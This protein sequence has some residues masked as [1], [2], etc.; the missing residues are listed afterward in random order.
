MNRFLLKFLMIVSIIS[1]G[2]FSVCAIEVDTEELNSAQNANIVFKNFEGRHSKIE[3]VF[4]I[5]MIGI[6]LANMQ[7]KDNIEFRYW[8]KYSVI[9]AVDDDTE[10]K[11][12]DGVIFSINKDAQV[13]HINN[14]RLIITGYLERKFGYSREDAVTLSKFVIYYNA[15]HRGDMD[16]FNNKF[17]T[18]V[19][20]HLTA[21]DA[22][23]STDYDQ[24]AGK[25]K[26]VIPLTQ[27]AGKGKIGSL[28]TSTLGGK[29]VVDSM[30]NDDDK[31]V[32]DRKEL[33]NIKKKQ[34]DETNKDIKKEK[35]AVNKEKEKTAKK[36]EKVAQKEK[37]IKEKK[38]SIAEK[39]KQLQEEKDNLDSIEDEDERREKEKELNKQEQELDKEKEKVEKDEEK[40][41]SERSEVEEEKA[42]NEKT[43]EIL[44]KKQEKVKEQEEEVK[45]EEKDVA[46]DERNNKIENAP[47]DIKEELK[48][49]SEALDKREEELDKRED[50][51]KKNKPDNKTF[52]AKLFYL[53]IKE[54]MEGGHYNNELYVIDMETK[55]VAPNPAVTNVCG[56]KYVVMNE[57]IIL[58]GFEGK[59]SSDHFLMVLD[60]NTLEEKARGKENIFFR[61]FVEVNEDNIYVILKEDDKYM[62]G[63]YDANLNL[64]AKSE[65]KIDSN[66]FISF[67][68]D[69]IFINDSAKNIIVLNKSDLSLSTKIAP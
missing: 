62:L 68:G 15:L 17:K 49:E 22:G 39:E 54:Y 25:T 47:E 69:E 21:E 1:A 60:R 14:I 5:R 55:K 58:V 16:N 3:S 27:F 57:G 20:Q 37:E 67:Y 2:M 53:K 40:V 64:L 33:I 45:K 38:D 10:S 4:D 66:T 61:S 11:L 30:K 32:S 48:K 34:I 31:G 35:D 8:N 56:N 12:L 6:R 19:T 29:D 28:D 7:N 13:D 23:I 52:A 44:A 36:E 26:I 9:Y 43:E 42:K 63:K 50:D 18:V 51:L 41:A 24:W 46:K 59:H 65:E